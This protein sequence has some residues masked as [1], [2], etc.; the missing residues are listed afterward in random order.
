VQEKF[1][2]YNLAAE[3]AKKY[4]HTTYLASP[5]N[6]QRGHG[7]LEHQVVL[8]VFA[9]S[10]FHFPH[11]REGLLLR[12]QSIKKL[13]HVHLMPILDM[14]IEQEQLFV[15]RE[16]LPNGS[17]RSRLKK[18]SPDHLELREA[19]TIVSQVGQAL[20]YAHERG[21]FH[22]NVKPENVL[23]NA[24]DQAV[25]ADFHLVSRNDVLIRDQT[26][27][28][29]AFCYMAPEQFAG[30]SDVRSDQYALGCL[31]Y[32]LI[33]GRVPFAAQ[34]LVSMMGQPSN[35]QPGLLSESVADLPPSLEAA[36]LK[37][38]AKDPDERFYD[39]SLF[40]EVIQSVLSPSPV[41]PLARSTHSRSR[42]TV[43]GL[44]QSA[45][46]E[47]ALSPIRKRVVSRPAEAV[48]SSPIR[49]WATMRTAP[50][51]L[52]PSEVFSSAEIDTAEP[53][54]TPLTPQ[55]SISE[56]AD[57]SQSLETVL[58][59]SQITSP[60]SQ[61]ADPLSYEEQALEEQEVNEASTP[62]L[63]TVPYSEG[64]TSQLA[65][66]VPI[67]EQEIDDWLPANSF[68]EEEAHMAV[69]ESSVFG[70]NEDVTAEMLPS[71]TRS[72]HDPETQSAWT[73][74]T[75]RS[76]GRVLR[77]TLLLSVI[78][79]LITSAF[80]AL[81]IFTFGEHLHTT[82]KMTR[83][84]ITNAQSTP[85]VQTSAQATT[86]LAVQPTVYVMSV[87]TVQSPIP[88]PIP[89]P[90]VIVTPSTSYEAEASS[91]TN[92]GTKIFSCN[93][94]S[95]GL[96]VG[97]ISYSI[98]LQFNNVNVNHDGNY[99]LKIY[100]LNSIAGRQTSAFV[101]VNGGPNVMVPD[102]QVLNVNCCDNIPPQ[103]TQMTIHLHA[104]NNTVK[105][106]SPTDYAPDI[107]RIV[108]E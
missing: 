96:R 28:E 26:A 103:V 9:S 89:T 93:L 108:V 55:A 59:L 13:Q 34:S 42:R 65:V 67:P 58:Q 52:E 64:P 84:V 7:E 91:N 81:G 47:T 100:Y 33:T 35:V 41:F 97:W 17:L 75:S 82:Q 43:S 80:W 46:A 104:G 18:I 11:E 45:K 50:Q 60:F 95:G 25:L 37:A 40:L 72:T 23:F 27:E 48:L 68:V 87:P 8:T 76:R 36:V 66:M 12:A 30:T 39:F 78:V 86:I 3:L 79:A 54:V 2:Q 74:P 73:L 106:S 20:A 85:K 102:I 15:M 24:H 90:A 31:A 10:L 61:D 62:M 22:G 63:D 98:F 53:V 88:I 56:A 38:L 51:P 49:K 4:S 19:L 6:P 32:E 1:H 14:G 70:Q 107:D 94:C 21:I 5:A 44:A 29:Y 77:Q 101:S 16:Y 83:V 92:N 105:I 99:T 57:S 69:A 71:L